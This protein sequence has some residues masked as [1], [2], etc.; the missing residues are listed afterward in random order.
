LNRV[1]FAAIGLV[2]VVLAGAAA[3]LS[4]A[5]ESVSAYGNG[6]G[7]SSTHTIIGTPVPFSLNSTTKVKGDYVAAGV[8]LRASTGSGT[9][10]LPAVPGGSTI[11][12]AL[13]YWSEINTVSTAALGMG[14][15]NGH[16]ITGS[17]YGTTAS[18]CWDISPS[19]PRQIY[20]YVSDVTAFASFGANSLTGFAS[21]GPPLFGGPEPLAEGASLIVVYTNAAS[22]G[23]QV[24][25]Y[26]GARSFA[27]PPIETLT[28]SGYVAVAGSSHTTWVVADGQ[29]GPPLQNNTHV[30]GVQTGTGNLNGGDGNFWDTNTQD[31]TANVPPADTSIQ[32]GAESGMPF[33]SS[34]CITWVA[35]VLS[36][37]INA[38]T[39]TVNKV[40]SPS[41]SV[42]AVPVSVTCTSGSP[43][44]ASGSA[45]PPASPFTITNVGFITPATCSA[46][47]T[48]P[49][50]YI[51][52]SNCTNVPLTN[53]V[54]ASCTITNTETSTTFTVNKV[55]VPGGPVTPVT[56]TVTCTSGIV[57]TPSGPAAPPASPH[58]T[59]VHKF[60]VSGTTCSASE[61][62]P[63]GY[64]E[65]DNCSNVP[66][67]NGVAASC[68][69][70]NTLAPTPNPSAVGG[71]VDLITPGSSGS[72]GAS[73]AWLAVIALAVVAIG[74]VAA[75]GTFAVVRK[76]S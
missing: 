2:V 51:M 10:T 23:H 63:A 50:G 49:A 27:G 4:L 57:T 60:N 38:T 48:V 37:P 26:Q 17:N 30:D 53:N 41:G 69:I 40:Y 44:A 32:V 5:P 15:I 1:G 58:T 3:L 20:N 75:G 7:T 9:I 74:T 70:T 6:D 29:P 28:M 12:K 34:D 8:G 43:A 72:G 24:D 25:V 22:T 67:S 61:A 45:A 64:L 73:D 66:I 76:R 36:T 62:V 68:T 11:T 47:E 65:S 19:S 16:A 46:T 52:T 31:V 59:V 39:F 71:F 55:Y 54:P 13:L 42:V 21:G 35:Q 56:V 14:S 33:G 18:P